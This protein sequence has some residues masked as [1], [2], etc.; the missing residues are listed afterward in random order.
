M[1]VLS[2]IVALICL[3]EL[4]ATIVVEQNIY[5]PLAMFT[6]GAMFGVEVIACIGILTVV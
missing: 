1:L 2:I 3:F 4:I 6:A 5:L